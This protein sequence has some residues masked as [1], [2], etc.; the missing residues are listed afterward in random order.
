[1]SVPGFF[2]QDF[3]RRI[4]KKVERLIPAGPPKWKIR[5]A[6]TEIGDY[7]YE[8]EIFDGE[9][10]LT[11]PRSF[12]CVASD[13]PGYVRICANDPGYFEF[14]DGTFFYPIGHNI[15]ATFNVKGAEV[16][17]LTT[18]KRE[19]TFAYDR[20]LDGMARGK[21]NFARIWL[22]AWS[23]GL[24]WSRR[25]HPSYR[26]LGRYNLENAWR[27]DY[28]LDKAERHGIY[29]QLALTT[30]GHF[31]SDPF[32]GDWAY[33]PYN[34]DNGGPLRLPRQ[35]WG[36]A[37]SQ[38]IYQ[39]MVRYAM[40]RWGYATHIAGWEICNEIDL[41]DN[42]RDHKQ[43]IIAWHNRCIKTIRRFDPNRHLVTTNFANWAEDDD[44]IG[45]AGISYSSTNHYRVQI[46]DAMRD[47]IYPRKAAHGK[48]AIMAECGY[49]FKG[50]TGETTERYLHVCLWSSCM[51]P[52]AGAGMSWWWDYVDDRDLY[53]RFRPLA[54]FAAGEDRR[55]RNLT[56]SR[57]ALLQE[58]GNPAP[59]LVADVLGNAE[60]A[61]FWVYERRL[62]R[63]EAD[64]I[65]VPEPREGVTLQL[66]G[67]A[68]GEYRVEFW[69]TR[70]GKPVQELTAAAKDG[71]LRVPVP[72]FTSDIAG[73]VKAVSP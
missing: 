30:F 28:V 46:V 27:F 63:A 12:T 20:F 57:G 54:E 51:M 9:T 49:D 18:E 6:P 64:P 66:K 65:F 71:S 70:K 4:D 45:L 16:L 44:I 7:S 43:E 36:H 40:A 72:R 8:I 26:G 68:D 38:E 15:P 11:S 48:P 33:S 61:Y 24:E 60:S 13:N 14:D 3:E 10:I 35:F 41:V 17:G 1:V 67:P 69:D 59:D 58:N 56:M 29:I 31:R 22:G 53:S 5:F 19:G 42:Y 2:Y 21:E 73:K 23:F 47:E 37:E 39:R 34:R 50:A 52:F 55:G 25:Y 32:E 62:M